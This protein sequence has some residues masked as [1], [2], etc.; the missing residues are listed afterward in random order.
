MRGACSTDPFLLIFLLHLLFLASFA[1][2]NCYYPNGQEADWTYAK[3][4]GLNMCCALERANHPGGNS[5]SGLTV[6]QCLPNG[7]CQND[8]KF[9]DARGGEVP[10]TR[11]FRD[12]CTSMDW[13]ASAGCLNVCTKE[14]VCIYENHESNQ[15]TSSYFLIQ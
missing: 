13:T 7:L 4:A 1:T 15:L 12:S 10:V 11:Y 8:V 6:D 9:T 2:G 3:C 5:S 14:S